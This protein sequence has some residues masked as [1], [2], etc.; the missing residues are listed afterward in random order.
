MKLDRK[1]NIFF[2]VIYLL[3][4]TYS[5]ITIWLMKFY[6]IGEIVKVL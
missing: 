4:N 3:R 2:L 1:E 6:T 5:Q